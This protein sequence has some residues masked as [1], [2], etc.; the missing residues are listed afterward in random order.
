[1]SNRKIALV[2]V[3]L[4]L[5]LSWGSGAAFAQSL[6][7]PV[8]IP[9]E[10]IHT[11]IVVQAKLAGKGPFN[12]LVDTDTDPSAIDVAT[13]RELGLQTGTKGYPATAGGTEGNVVHVTLPTVEVGSLTA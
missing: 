13:A 1:M 5:L 10:F 9:F 2:T 4:L 3:T 11:Q 7:A 6:R 8:E 12:M